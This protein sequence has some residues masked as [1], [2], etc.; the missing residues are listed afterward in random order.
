MKAKFR[1]I[2][3][4]A[5]LATALSFSP[6]LCAETPLPAL[7]QVADSTGPSDN[8]VGPVLM[9]DESLDQVL[10]LLEAL[11]GKT[12]L[13]PQTLPPIQLNLS[14]RKRITKEEAV[15]AIQTLLSLNGI[16]VTAL[17][18]NFLK[19]TPLAGV[20]S[21]TPELIAGSTLTLPAS[22]QMASKLFRLH[23]LR[24]GEFTPQ[25]AGML[26]SAGGAPAV[27]ERANAVLVT[28]TVSNLK[29]IE[30]LLAQLDVPPDA[31]YQPKF[32]TLNFA[33]AGEVVGKLRAILS[34]P[35]GSQFSAATTYNPDER[36]NQIILLADP[37]QQALFDELI[38]K[39]DVHSGPNAR[40]DYIYLKHASAKEVATTL[41]QLVSGQKSGPHNAAQETSP[42]N[43]T[44]ALTVVPPG[45]VVI[46]TPNG[47]AQ[48]LDAA[49]FSSVLTIMPEERSNA[50]IV[51]GTADDLLLIHRLVERIDI[52]LAQV[53]IEVI[54]AE[55]TLHDTDTSG[56]S[57]LNLTVAPNANGITRVTDFAGS[58]AGWS[59]TNGI[60][61]PTS[62]K[63]ALGDTGSKNFVRILSAPTIMTTH[64]KEAEI[65][66]GQS[67]PV[68][69]GSQASPVGGTSSG[70]ATNSTVTY[71]D[72]AIALKVTPLIG[73]DG[74]IQLKIDQKVDDII[75][76]ITIDNNPQPIIGR[77]QATSF[78]NVENDQMVVLGGL[79]RNKNTRS[80]TKLGFLVEIPILSHLLGGRKKEA[81]RTELLLFIRPHVIR[82]KEANADTLRQIDQ[83]SNKKEVDEFLRAKKPKD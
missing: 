38:A 72:I 22:G 43:P 1:D 4:L 71:K 3:P 59:V 74:T 24:A 77:R 49:Q 41:S 55:V 15:R 42:P 67:Q 2:Y 69:T 73:D 18:D 13:R 45:A 46:T 31:S 5:C 78:I 28:D 40:T 23:F 32:Y 35:L 7:P 66:V 11:T 33:K 20:K 39:L 48:T 14:L 8:L 25:I 82:P 10:T 12:L 70:F 30:T 44:S 60:V 53:R 58:V 54:I 29:R 75:G 68:I 63:A 62:F 79:Q 61:D 83:M 64:N 56:I 36:T 51:S 65:L 9:Q 6:I 47:P 81:E 26:N 17:D 37:Q 50:L 16:A 76:N 21:E 19:V 34:G 52:V 80:R 57:A 27:F